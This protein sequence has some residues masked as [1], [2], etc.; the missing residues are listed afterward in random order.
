MGG[1]PEVFSDQC[2]SGT[3]V[4]TVSDDYFARSMKLGVANE[5]VSMSS[6]TNI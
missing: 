1:E 3:F 4:T 2:L 5:C 6:T